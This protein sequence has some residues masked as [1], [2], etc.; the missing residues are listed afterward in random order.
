MGKNHMHKIG[1]N[2]QT[3][4]LAGVSRGINFPLLREFKPIRLPEMIRNELV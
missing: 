3:Q 1:R 2:L 4:L